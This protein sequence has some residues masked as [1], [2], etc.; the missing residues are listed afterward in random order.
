S[1][2]A[3]G[4]D[5]NGS[6]G[7]AGSGVGARGRRFERS[8][9]YAHPHHR[10]EPSVP[11]RLTSTYVWRTPEVSESLSTTV[12]LCTFASAIVARPHPAGARRFAR[13]HPDISQ[14]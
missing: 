1:N 5:L 6:S 10:G 9:Q 12:L 14:L 7:N 4:F 3:T 2:T 13:E 11:G 8:F